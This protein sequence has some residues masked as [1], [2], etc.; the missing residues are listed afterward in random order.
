LDTENQ[1]YVIWDIVVNVWHLLQ[2]VHA[3]STHTVLGSWVL[4][5][6]IIGATFGALLLL[7]VVLPIRPML[8]SEVELAQPTK[9][10]ARGYQPRR[11]AAEQIGV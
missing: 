7:R 9:A 8:E 10:R 1:G 4:V 6:A 5:V 2:R 3:A 11:A